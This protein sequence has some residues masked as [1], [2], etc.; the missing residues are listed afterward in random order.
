MLWPKRSQAAGAQCHQQLAIIAL[1]W[2]PTWRDE[3]SENGRV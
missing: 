2:Q 3:Q 1:D